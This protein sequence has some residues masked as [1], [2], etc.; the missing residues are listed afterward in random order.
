MQ[1][2]ASKG[3]KSN[4]S[5]MGFTC[6]ND[7]AGYR[8]WD[9]SVLGAGVDSRPQGGGRSAEPSGASGG[10][11]SHPLGTTRPQPGGRHLAG[12]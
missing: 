3:P 7:D 8:A 4:G 6:L 2:R 12:P 5:V 10:Q 1:Q 9:A 11:L